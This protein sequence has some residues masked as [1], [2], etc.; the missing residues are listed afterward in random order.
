[1]LT[2]AMLGL[3]EQSGLDILVR[4]GELDDQEFFASRLTRF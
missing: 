4:T 2:A 3:I 1:M